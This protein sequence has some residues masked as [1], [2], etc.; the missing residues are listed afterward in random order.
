VRRIRRGKVKSLVQVEHKAGWRL[1]QSVCAAT[2]PRVQQIRKPKSG[3][4]SHQWPASPYAAGA[5]RIPIVFKVL[6]PAKTRLRRYFVCAN[7]EYTPSHD[8]PDFENLNVH[9]RLC[10]NISAP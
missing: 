6:V 9:P 8:G 5:G 2:E 10:R 7:L 1:G 4:C 3:M